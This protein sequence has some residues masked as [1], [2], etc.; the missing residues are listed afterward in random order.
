MVNVSMDMNRDLGTL[1]QASKTLMD[2]TK[3]NQAVSETIQAT[4]TQLTND[5]NTLEKDGKLIKCTRF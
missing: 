3:A 2:N 1:I 5:V 4:M